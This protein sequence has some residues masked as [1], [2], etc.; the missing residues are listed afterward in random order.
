[1]TDKLDFEL[2]QVRVTDLIQELRGFLQRLEA[3]FGP[4]RFRPNEKELF[5][6]TLILELDLTVRA[7]NCLKNEGIKTLGELS[8]KSDGELLHIPNFGR[9]SLYD[10]KEAVRLHQLRKGEK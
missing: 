10:L 5:E 8:M 9:K 2:L 4:S 3:E 1:M 7:Q 6:D